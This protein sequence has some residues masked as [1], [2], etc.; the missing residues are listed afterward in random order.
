MK[1]KKY[2]KNIKINDKVWSCEFNWGKV[3]DIDKTM[4]L[5]LVR[6]DS[7]ENT[8]WYDLDGKR[9]KKFNQTLFWKKIKFN[10]RTK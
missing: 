4:S 10:D 6:F 7:A 3:I 9:N 5:I 1:K 2:F 8:Y